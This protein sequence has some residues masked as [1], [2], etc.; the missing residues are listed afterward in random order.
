MTKTGLLISKNSAAETA[1]FGV[2]LQVQWLGDSFLRSRPMQRAP[3][4]TWASPFSPSSA[5]VLQL[6]E[7]ISTL[8]S[9]HEVA[10]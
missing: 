3:K 9:D 4:P 8:Y 5:W 1:M 6:S 2:F 7:L 10:A